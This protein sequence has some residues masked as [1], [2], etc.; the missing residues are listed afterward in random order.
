M[1]AL[2]LSILCLIGSFTSHAAEDAAVQVAREH[3]K[4]LVTANAESL[5]KSYAPEVVLMPGH[6]FLKPDYGLANDEER[7]VAVK[8]TCD[9]L[10]AEIVKKAAGR[11]GP[12]QEKLDAM[13]SALRF[14][15]LEAKEGDL[16]L[17]ASDEVATP[18]GKLHFTI[19]N[20]DTVLKVVQPKGDFGLLHLRKA[21]DRWVIVSEYLD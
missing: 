17:E 12:P 10:I 20:E 16:A 19:R 6:E 9:A 4:S 1:K 18:D 5:K 2:L 3:L 13:L 7:K 8:V 14:E 21:D 11:P 15:A